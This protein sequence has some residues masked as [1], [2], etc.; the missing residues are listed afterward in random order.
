MSTN[1]EFPTRQEDDFFTVVGN[2]FQLIKQSW[3]AF[4]LNAWTFIALMLA[5]A[6]L[7]MILFFPLVFG[8]MVASGG[9]D[10]SGLLAGVGG[11]FMLLLFVL[12]FVLVVM[13]GVASVVTQLASVRGNKITV[14]EAFNLSKPL[15]VPVVVL[16]ILSSL[17][18]FAGLILLIIPGLLAMFFLMAAPFY[19][20]DKKMGASDAM[21]ASY[22]LIK[23]NWKVA[24]AFVVVNIVI[25]IPSYVPVIGSLISTAL[26]IAYFCLP[27]IL[28]TRLVGDKTPAP[29]VE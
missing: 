7:A 18:I 4:K 5:P 3:E 25:S 15:F 23:A 1:S 24:A 10:D 13:L 28:W 20:V 27:A 11:I 17:V 21:K 14:G 12:F 26:S 19:V 29:T 9:G 22:E 16:A 6:V 8:G 2:A